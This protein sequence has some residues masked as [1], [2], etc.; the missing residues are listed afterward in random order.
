[1]MAASTTTNKLRVGY[2]PEHFSAPLLQLIENDK[3]L[4]EWIELVPNPSG[5]GQM[6]TALKDRS[7]HLA[8]ALTES[9]IAGIILG[10]GDYKLIGTYVTSPLNWAVITG[11]N[12]KYKSITDLKGQKMGISRPGSGSQV[13]ASVMALQ[14]GWTNSTDS[15][16]EFVVKDS[17]KNLRDSVNDGSTAAF[18][19][20]WFTTKPYQDSGEVKFIV[21]AS[22]ES[23]A[24]E[25]LAPPKL[26]IFL[27]KLDESINKF[28]TEL[29]IRS[30]EN[31]KYI[32]EKFDQREEDVKEWMK[33]VSYPK[34]THEISQK[35]LEETV[36]DLGLAGVIPDS[37]KVMIPDQLVNTEVAKVTNA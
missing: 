8:V 7:I 12:T 22:P 27:D 2:V 23:V 21:A 4:A 6:I 36:K 13:M 19:W 3:E 25:L 26:K 32:Q 5:T 14:Q 24:P 34:K 18:M 28:G 30:V 10:K 11:A 35:T 20:E 15:A 37:N 31:V 9:L 17:F 1:M 29:G 33:G 16:T